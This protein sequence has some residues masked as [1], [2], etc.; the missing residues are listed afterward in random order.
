MSSPAACIFCWMASA[1]ACASMSTR[2]LGA[3]HRMAFSSMSAAL[4]SNT[5]PRSFMSSCMICLR[6]EDAVPRM[7][8][9]FW[10]RNAMNLGSRALIAAVAA[11]WFMVARC[12]GAQEATGGQRESCVQE[13]VN[14]L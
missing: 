8:R 9:G 11:A 13:G 14:N 3:S 7:M 10:A 12:G 2:S 1:L 5:A 6:L 4:T